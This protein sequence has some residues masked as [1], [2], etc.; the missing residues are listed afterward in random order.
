M[1]I[2]FSFLICLLL[3]GAYSQTSI[4][5][6]VIDSLTKA[7]VEFAN[8]GVISKAFGTVTDEKGGFELMVP[9]SLKQHKIRIS[10]LGYKT[11]DFKYSDLKDKHTVV[12]APAA[13]HL[14]EV[15][16]KPKR[17]PKF[18][19]LGN[20]TKSTGITCGFTS[21][22]LGCEMAV[23]LNI[24]H[25]ETWL[26]KLSF[27]I[28]R[29]VY[30]SLIFRV[31]VYKMD[32][33]GNPG[34][35]MLTQNLFVTPPSKTGLVEVDLSKYYLFADDDVYVSIEWIKDLGDT[36]GLFFSCQMLGG[37]YFREASQ[38]RWNHTAAVGVGLFV[39][40]QY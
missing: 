1:R 4:K 39:D 31:N 23:K 9:D 32:K 18:K 5:C 37:T 24:K 40:V 16:I 22:K 28:V 30:D 27:N 26:K 20:E 19:T 38:G 29:N 34:E 17:D 7:P 10:M 3:T 36:K 35:N 12:L 11:K 13:F 15:T 2:S 33:D 25:K 8:V 6:T 14:N 21:N